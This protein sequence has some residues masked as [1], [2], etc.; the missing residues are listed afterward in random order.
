MKKREDS[1]EILMLYKLEDDKCQIIKLFGYEFVEENRNICKLMLE[2]KEKNLN[3]YIYINKHGNDN[4]LKIKLKGINGVNKLT[5]MFYNCFSL[6]GI[7]ILSEWNTNNVTDM[8][9]IFYNCQS[10]KELP[11]ISKW[12]TDKVNNIS[13]MFYGCSSLEKILD[14][15]D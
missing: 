8:S 6:L 9:Y 4:I 12:K 13:F 1:Y 15:F 7:F 2:G 5:K 14:I 10:L 3:E 11:D